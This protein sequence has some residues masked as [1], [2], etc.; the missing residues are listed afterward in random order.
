MIMSELSQYL[1]SN[2]RAALK[3]LSHRFDADPEALRGM[4][5]TLERKGR[6]RKLPAATPCAGGCCGCDPAKVEI[7]E[8]TG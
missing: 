7:Y 3:D 6:V 8:W 1:R 4:L 2:G 5:V